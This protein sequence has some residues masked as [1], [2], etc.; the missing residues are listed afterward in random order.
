MAI[1]HLIAILWSYSV[2]QLKCTVNIF[3]YLALRRII[4]I[5]LCGRIVQLTLLFTLAT[6]FGELFI[7]N[8][9]QHRIHIP[10]FDNSL[11]CHLKQFVTLFSNFHIPL[12]CC[13][14]DT[15][16]FSA[17]GNLII[18]FS[19]AIKSLETIKCKRNATRQ[20]LI[21]MKN[22]EIWRIFLP[23]IRWYSNGWWCFW[24]LCFVAQREN[25]VQS[26]A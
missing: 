5:N 4:F 6:V 7:L 3:S 22:M 18:I 19:Y 1:R 11:P 13:P 2:F 20:T 24:C 16:K 14:V 23:C 8:R 9:A 26:V 25:A 15:G 12:K 21:F 10:T 17:A